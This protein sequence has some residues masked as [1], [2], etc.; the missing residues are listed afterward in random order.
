MKRTVSSSQ[1]SVNRQ[2]NARLDLVD[3]AD[4][5]AS[6]ITANSKTADLKT[7]D[8]PIWRTLVAARRGDYSR[9]EP[10][11]N[12]LLYEHEYYSQRVSFAPKLSH[13][14]RNDCWRDRRRRC[15][16]QPRR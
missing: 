12:S 4:A 11:R 16:D 7:G 3:V 6:T 2:E 1:L 15:R 8:H 13:C 9:A 5:P 14:F 10:P